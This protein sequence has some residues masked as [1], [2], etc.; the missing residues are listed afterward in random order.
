MSGIAGLKVRESDR[1]LAYVRVGYGKLT[2]SGEDLEGMVIGGGYEFQ[3][4]SDTNMRF[5]YKKL[6]YKDVDFP[7]N[8]VNYDGHEIAMGMVFRF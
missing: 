1:D 3:I 7:D 8:V 6:N 5:D 2:R 4:T